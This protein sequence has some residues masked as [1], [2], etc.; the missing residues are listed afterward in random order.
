MPNAANSGANVHGIIV[1][2]GAGNAAKLDALRRKAGK[3]NLPTW[4]V[5]FGGGRDCDLA[6]F[7]LMMHR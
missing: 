6:P 5:S 2:R 3:P 4:F 7:P 1:E